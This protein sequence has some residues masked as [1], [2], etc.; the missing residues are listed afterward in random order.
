MNIDLCIY[1]STYSFIYVSISIYLAHQATWPRLVGA[2]GAESALSPL[3]QYIYIY[4]YIHIY[5][6]I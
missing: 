3:T 5:I 1:L 2:N 6:Y 4:I